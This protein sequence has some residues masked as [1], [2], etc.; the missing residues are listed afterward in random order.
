MQPAWQSRHLQHWFSNLFIELRGSLTIS[1][2]LDGVHDESP[3][4]DAVS[5]FKGCCRIRPIFPMQSC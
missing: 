5:A 4:F 2:F 3:D 1:T